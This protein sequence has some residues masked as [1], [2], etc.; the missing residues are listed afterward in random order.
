M[1]DYWYFEA[2]VNFCPI[3]YFV[4]SARVRLGSIS[5]EC[6]EPH[7]AQTELDLA[8]EHYFSGFVGSVNDMVGNSSGGGDL[9]GAF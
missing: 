3:L 8:A 5:W 2:H 6:E 4:A 1:W 7:N 9:E